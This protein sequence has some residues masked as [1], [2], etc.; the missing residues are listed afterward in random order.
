MVSINDDVATYITRMRRYFH[1]N[2]ELSFQE[3]N[4]MDVVRRELDAMGYRT[5]MVE[6]GGIIAD[7]GDGKGK[8]IAVRADMDA[9][10]VEEEN[11]IPYRSKNRGVMHACGHD[12]HTAMLLGLAKIFSKEKPSGFNVRFLFQQAEESP[13]G[14]AKQLIASGALDGIDYVIGQHV[15]SNFDAGTVGIISGPAMANAD[16]FRVRIDGKGGHGSEPERAVDSIVVAS[17]F[18]NS[19]Q[20]IVSRNISPFSPAVVTVGTF[21]SGYRYNIIA[22][23]AEL[24][25][26]VR[27]YTSEDRD[28]IKKRIEEILKGTCA[29]SG[30]TYRY[31]YI[32][33]YPVLINDPNVTKIMED[34]AREV[35]GSE[36]I[37]HPNPKMGG[38]DFAYYTQRVAGSFLF[39]GVRN[40]SIGIESPQHSPTYNIDESALPIGTEILYR[41]V[42]RLSET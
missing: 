9:L 37:N 39:L 14:G 13:P 38:E 7:A 5:R 22:A 8:R 25:G 11:D 18:V 6:R 27:T 26:T 17:S 29:Y 34:A 32:Q 23:H 1:E 33:G 4:T 30:A 3:N 2:P 42:R 19:L 20:T 35:V 28:K 31:E 36:G 21:M 24:T 10:P 16:E 40:A 15:D 41:W 12:A